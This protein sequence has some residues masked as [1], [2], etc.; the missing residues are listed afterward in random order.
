MVKK[1]NKKR[2]QTLQARAKS[3]VATPHPGMA[4]APVQNPNP[5][6]AQ[7]PVQNPNAGMAQAPVQNPNPG[8][9]QNLT[10]SVPAAPVGEEKKTASEDSTEKTSEKH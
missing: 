2:L 4:Q 3:C 5:G 1:H 9:A 8:M 10:N 6:M 7:A